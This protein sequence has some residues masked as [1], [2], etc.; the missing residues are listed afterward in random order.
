M[1]CQKPVNALLSCNI[2][3]PNIKDDLFPV[4]Y[5]DLLLNQ[6]NVK[7]DFDKLIEDLDIST[8]LLYNFL[9]ICDDITNTVLHKKL[10]KRDNVYII[11]GDVLRRRYEGIPPPLKQ[12]ASTSKGKGNEKEK[13]K[14]Y[15][16]SKNPNPAAFRLDAIHSFP[17]K[18]SKTIVLL[19]N[20][21][22]TFF[23]E[24]LLEDNDKKRI[25]R[26]C[27]VLNSLIEFPFMYTLEKPF[28][29]SLHNDIVSS[30]SS[31]TS[32]LP[33]CFYRSVHFSFDPPSKRVAVAAV[34][35]NND[36]DADIP[37][38][39]RSGESEYVMINIEDIVNDIPANIEWK[40]IYVFNLSDVRDLL[41]TNVKIYRLFKMFYYTY[42][43]NGARWSIHPN[44]NNVD[45]MYTF[46]RHF[47]DEMLIISKWW[48]DNETV[49][50]VRTK[51][52]RWCPQIFGSI[53][54]WFF[55]CDVRK[56]FSTAPA[57][58]AVRLPYVAARTIS[59]GGQIWQPSTLAYMSLV[60]IGVGTS[61]LIYADISNENQGRKDIVGY[62]NHLFNI[63]YDTR[64]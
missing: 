6:F 43:F 41:M 51:L 31:S 20:T 63:E 34:D 39:S 54:D 14:K 52:Q 4:I 9:V 56:I 10:P 64:I 28:K 40:S 59:A 32:S 47:D 44:I 42:C 35:N 36:D 22:K 53:S 37:Q 33:V 23:V 27:V 8:P 38:R 61:T 25:D 62:Y 46:R 3:I 30:G 55:H 13:K 5:T 29:I 12:S 24:R 7:D 48:P 17:Q 60:R 19:I 15:K 1:S 58:D 49:S 2:N 57:N 21:Y 16:V 26:V 45:T 18:D 50:L 11:S